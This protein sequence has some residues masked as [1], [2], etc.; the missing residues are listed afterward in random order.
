MYVCICSAVTDR[1]IRE[2]VDR[3]ARSLPDVQQALPVGVCCGLCRHSA[4][5]VIEEHRS[6]RCVVRAVS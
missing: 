4:E 3:G 6:A 2:I 5:Q 1:Q